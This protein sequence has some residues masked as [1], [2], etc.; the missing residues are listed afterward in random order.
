MLQPLPAVEL[1]GQVQLVRIGC[2]LTVDPTALNMV[3]TKIIVGICKIIQCI[4]IGQKASLG[5]PVKLHPVIN[6]PGKILQLRI[7]FQQSIHGV[8]SYLFQFRIDIFP[9]TCRLF[10]CSG[11]FEGRK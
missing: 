1:T 10:F 5:V 9:A 6:V 2:P 7:Q 3:N 8:F 4:A 11:I